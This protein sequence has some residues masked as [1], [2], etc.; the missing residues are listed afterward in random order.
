MSKWDFDQVERPGTLAGTHA[1]NPYFMFATGIEGSCPTIHEGRTRV[2]QLAKSRHYEL[3]KTDFDRV[4]ELGI[5]F[6]RYGPPIHRSFVGPGKY[7]WDFADL[8]FGDLLRRDIAPIVDLCHFG[9]PEWIGNFQN[10]DFPELFAQY[11]RAFAER[12]PWV[13]LYT[14]VNEM[15][16]CALFSGR[17]GWWNEQL[18]SDRGFV[19]ALKHLVKANVLASREIL[20][21]RPDAIFIQSESSEYYHPDNPA[22]IAPAEAMNLERF[23]SLDFNYGHVVDATMYSYLL[24][25]DM[26]EEEYLFFT[27][28]SLRHHCIVGSD[29]YSTN[30]HRVAADG[31]TSA[32]GE[33]LGYGELAREYYERYR[34]PIMHTETNLREGTGSADGADWLWRQWESLYHVRN[35]GLP[36]VG[37]TWYSLT[38]QIDWD[39]ALREEN[40]HVNPVG[41]F[42]LERRI[43]PVGEAYK[44]LISEW[45]YVLPARS[46]CLTV[47]IVMPSESAEPF[48]KRRR[49]WMRKYYDH[50]APAA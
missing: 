14:P 9:A 17:Y 5:T 42:D 40:G 31:S 33:V 45:Q 7:D 32:S 28:S 25:N 15:Y 22:A 8:T 39:T 37:F 13:Q 23:L 19:T 27:D 44:K 2:D 4:E 38:D 20:A 48:A 47:P 50:N 46:V 11:A 30:E 6:L 29:Y 21:V 1:M 43:R 3:W 41:L 35:S 26:S 49:E 34:L 16:V 24:D 18:S 10:P 36:T 12:F